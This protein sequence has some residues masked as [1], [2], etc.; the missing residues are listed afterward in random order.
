MP[1]YNRGDLPLWFWEGEGK[2]MMMRADGGCWGVSDIS[3]IK[4]QL[5]GR[6]DDEVWCGMAGHRGGNA[7]KMSCTQNTH[8]PWSPFIPLSTYSIHPSIHPS[9]Y[10]VILFIYLSTYSIH[11]FIVYLSTHSPICL[12]I[13]SVHPSIHPPVYLLILFISVYLF[14]L[15][16]HSSICLLILFIHLLILSIHSSPYLFIHLS[17]Y[18]LILSVHP[19]TH[20]CIHPSSM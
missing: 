4:K 2:I 8:I 7:R 12:L 1:W 3:V 15:S 16:T 19:F 18:L 17:L 9:F 13:L 14:Y 10:W 5:G 11:P 20:L 6:H